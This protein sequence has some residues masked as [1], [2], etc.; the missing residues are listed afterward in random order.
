MKRDDTSELKQLGNQKTKYKYEEPSVEILETFRNVFPHRKYVVELIFPEFTSLCPK[1]GQPDF[2]TI[3]ICYVPK[4]KCIES[5]S[6]KLYMF[7]F[8]SHG[9]FME[10][11]VNTILEDCVEVCSPEWMVVEGTFNA[12]GGICINVKAEYTIS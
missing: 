3:K 9:S 1:T 10:T 7:A 8:R 4:E 12:R 2:A 11:I 6:F 5:K